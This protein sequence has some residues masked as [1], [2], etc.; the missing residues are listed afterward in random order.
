MDHPVLPVSHPL[1]PLFLPENFKANLNTVLFTHKELL[2]DKDTDP[3]QYNHNTILLPNKIT[4]DE[5]LT[6]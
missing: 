3:S 4:K 2:T 1:S 6:I 5:F